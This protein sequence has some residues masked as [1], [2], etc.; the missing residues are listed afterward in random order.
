MALKEE[1]VQFL[2]TVQ[3]KSSDLARLVDGLT[4]GQKI[5]AGQ[6]GAKNIK[7]DSKNFDPLSGSL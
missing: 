6:D 2:V 4:L 5:Y 1:L 3:R 7:G